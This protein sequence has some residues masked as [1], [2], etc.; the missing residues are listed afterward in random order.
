MPVLA[1]KCLIDTNVLI[2]ATLRNDSRFAAARRVLEAAR[3]REFAAFITVQN[4]AEMY[5]N[6]TGPKSKPPDSPAVARTKIQSI[7][8]LRYLEILPI[9]VQVIEKA[10]E[11]CEAR[12]I[13]KQDYFDMQLVAAMLLESIPTIVTEN[14]GDFSGI[15]GISAINP[16]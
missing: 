3:D 15:D 5:P 9:T 10:L 12:Q 6:L 8:G 4:L 11:L 14:A 1:G 7:S 13:K 2:Y 16:F